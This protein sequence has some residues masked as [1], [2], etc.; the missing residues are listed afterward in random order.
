M[1]SIL[2]AISF[3]FLTVH[4]HSQISNQGN[5]APIEL[6]Y[7]KVEK[8]VP[9]NK[10]FWHAPCVTEEATFEIQYAVNNKDFKTIESITASRVRCEQP[11]EFTD[12]S[13]NSSIHYYRL[14]MINTSNNFLINSYTVAVVNKAGG[15]KLNALLPSV[16]QSNAV[17]SISAGENDQV[18][19]TITGINGKI[20]KQI[21]RQVMSG[22]NQIHLQLSDL[23]RGVYYLNAVNSKGVQ[24]TIS[25]S[26]Q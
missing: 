2:L 20:H 24:E 26:K 25:F 12:V 21:T 15:L 7:F 4:L 3:L 18:N 9:Q 17:L 10:I 1:K 11:F 8:G 6:K 22:T 16:V 13:R 14:R 19:I 5:N 23:A